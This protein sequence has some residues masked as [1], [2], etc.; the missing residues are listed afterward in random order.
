MGNLDYKEFSRRRRPH[1]NPLDGT[2]FLTFRLAGS[3]PKSE[4]RYYRAKLRWL[5]DHLRRIQKQCGLEPSTSL[6]EL[7][8]KIEMHNRDWFRKTEEILHRADHGPVWLSE[9]AVADKVAENLKRLDG[10]AYRLDAYSI[11]SNHV[12][13]VFNPFLSPADMLKVFE[14]ELA[15]FRLIVHPG[16]SKIMLAL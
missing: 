8:E 5:Q 7:K 11:M 16:L 9:P 15:S 2:L 10:E 6:I 3:I 13:S 12:H 14:G 4:V 1:Y